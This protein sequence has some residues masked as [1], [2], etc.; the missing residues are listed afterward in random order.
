MSDWAISGLLKRCKL[1]RSS[2]RKLS[3]DSFCSRVRKIGTAEVT[4]KS[5]S[6]AT[7]ILRSGSARLASLTR[8]NATGVASLILSRNARLARTASDRLSAP[9][10][11]D[12]LLQRG[13]VKFLQIPLKSLLHASH[14]PVSSFRTRSA[15][16]QLNEDTQ[17]CSTT[18]G[19]IVR[20]LS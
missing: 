12:L 2:A 13:R 6:A 9:D 1:P 3:E 15:V 17:I 19:R 11:R 14:Q 20:A 16:Q 5:D 8:R 10:L 7:R 4:R 18:F